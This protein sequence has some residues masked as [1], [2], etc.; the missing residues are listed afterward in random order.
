MCLSSNWVIYFFL[1]CSR[2]TGQVDPGPGPLERPPQWLFRNSAHLYN[3]LPSFLLFYIKPTSQCVG[4]KYIQHLVHIGLIAYSGRALCHTWNHDSEREVAC[5]LGDRTL[6]LPLE[7]FTESVF[8]FPPKWCW[9]YVEIFFIYRLREILLWCLYATS[10]LQQLTVLNSG[11][12]WFLEDM[13][14]HIKMCFF[15]SIC[16]LLTNYQELYL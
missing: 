4:I 1:F 8:P 13:D 7:L 9:I 15:S 12:H 2:A 14:H 10:N 3:F 16:S 6:G 5:D 11:S